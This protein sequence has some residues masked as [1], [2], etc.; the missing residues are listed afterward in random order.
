[1]DQLQSLFSLLTGQ[2]QSLQRLLTDYTS[3]LTRMITGIRPML[4]TQGAALNYADVTAPG[5]PGASTTT[6]TAT[7]TSPGESVLA[8][9]GTLTQ[10]F[11]QIQKV[12]AEM[13]QQMN[14][15]IETGSK[16]MG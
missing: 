9:I 14:R 16:A 12:L 2:L 6:T 10:Q 7:G 5:A 1:M 3:Q 11:T 4:L 8:V 13:N 15:M